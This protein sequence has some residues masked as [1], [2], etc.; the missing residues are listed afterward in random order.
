MKIEMTGPL[1]AQCLRVGAAAIALTLITVSAQAADESGGS[2]D[3]G[4]VHPVAE[5]KKVG[6]EIGHGVKKATREIGHGTRK[7]TKVV[8]HGF[9]DAT[10]AAGHGTRKVTKEIGHAFRDGVHEAEGKKD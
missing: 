9:R 10:R 4:K 3:S 7:A 1:F 8:G 5:A 2:A 6:K